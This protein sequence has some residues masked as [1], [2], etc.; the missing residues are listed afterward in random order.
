LKKI[1]ISFHLE[2]LTLYGDCI[3]HWGVDAIIDFRDFLK[4]EARKLVTYYGVNDNNTIE[5]NKNIFN[6]LVQESNYLHLNPEVCH[7]LCFSGVSSPPPQGRAP[8]CNVVVLMIHR[9]GFY[10]HEKSIARKT[11]DL[12]VRYPSLKE[13]APHLSWDTRTSIASHILSAVAVSVISLRIE[14]VQQPIFVVQAR[15]VLTEYKL[16]RR[17]KTHFGAADEQR[18]TRLRDFVFA[19]PPHKL[20]LEDLSVKCGTL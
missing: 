11:A 1:L 6:R 8:F 19:D 4:S 20:F 5:Y 18:F 7:L 3:A 10:L 9:Q 12:F 16:G 2:A 17:R 13:I 15:H 14:D